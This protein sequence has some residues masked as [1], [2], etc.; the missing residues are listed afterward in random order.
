MGE[1]VEVGCTGLSAK[2]RD[3]DPLFPTAALVLSGFF[4]S[5]HVLSDT[6]FNII[7]REKCSPVRVTQTPG[8]AP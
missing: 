7:Y 4:L 8:S 2:E 6:T 3:A 5:L 1:L